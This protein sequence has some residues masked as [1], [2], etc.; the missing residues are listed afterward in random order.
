MNRLRV[1]LVCAALE[2]SA[3]SGTPMRPEEI[4]DL[5]HQL[6]LPKLARALP[7]EQDE[8]DIPG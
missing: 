6:N 2:F 3:L 7:A 5:M 4:Q 1:L 8:G